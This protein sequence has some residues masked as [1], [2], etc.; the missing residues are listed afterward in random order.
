VLADV[1]DTPDVTWKI[2]DD[3]DGPIV[4]A[5]VTAQ[6]RAPDG[7][8]A[9]TPVNTVAPGDYTAAP[10]LSGPGDWRLTFTSVAPADVMEVAIYALPAGSAAPWAPSLR[11]VG[12][13]IP[14]RTRS[15]T[16]NEVKGS[17]DDDTAPSGE[18]V[19]GLIQSAVATVAGMVGAPIAPTAYPLCSAAAAL[20]S[21]YWVEL[22]YPERDGDVSVYSRLRDDALLLTQKAAEVNVGAGGGTVD[23][24]GAGDEDDVLGLSSFCFPAA[25]R[26]EYV[27]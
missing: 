17:F 21:A 25:P 19:Y 10:L 20:W 22:A 11:D 16:T 7:T 1:G 4:P 24:P 13:H 12:C 3:A 15:V 9:S 23:P 8:V 26:G 2:R 27:L 18:S 6:L 14:S 5:S